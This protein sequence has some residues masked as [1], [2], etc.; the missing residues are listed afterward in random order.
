MLRLCRLHQGIQ[1]QVELTHR[2]AGDFRDGLHLLHASNTNFRYPKRAA[3]VSPLLTALCGLHGTSTVGAE[4]ALRLDSQSTRPA[5]P[6]TRR[7]TGDAVARLMHADVALLTEDH[8][9]S[10]L[11]VGLQSRIVLLIIQVFSSRLSNTHRSADVA[12]DPIIRVFRLFV[13]LEGRMDLFEALPLKFFHYTFHLELGNGRS[14][15]S[16]WINAC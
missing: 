15:W 4:F 16:A 6:R 3:D 2:Y 11:R 9:V 12:D 8:L 14:T 1:A 13:T 7:D 10:L 5:N